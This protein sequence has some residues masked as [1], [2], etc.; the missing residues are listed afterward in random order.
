MSFPTFTPACVEAY[1]EIVHEQYKDAP[2]LMDLVEFLAEETDELLVANRELYDFYDVDAMG[3]VNLDILGRIVDVP[4][5][6]DT[7]A[8][9]R[10]R[11]KMGLATEINGTPNEIIAIVKGVYN[12]SFAEY[13]PEYPAG[14]F[15]L[16]DAPSLSIDA[17][18]R[19][20][21][22][23]VMAFPGCILTLS[24]GDPLVLDATQE[25]I[26]LV[27]PCF[28]VAEYPPDEVWDGGVG[29]INPDEFVL[30]QPWPFRDGTGVGTQPDGGSG[31]IDPILFTF[32]DGSYAED[33]G[34]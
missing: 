6:G 22:A 29:A 24:D 1:P 26:M 33:L 11:I 19:I 10:P 3:G 18:E 20:S 13:V 7:D 4:R 2:N 8:A 32:T 17:L 27:G 15:I 31:Q 28:P 34:G 25:Y 21:P 14:Y 9:Y 16:T 23:G 30:T 12:G 5:N